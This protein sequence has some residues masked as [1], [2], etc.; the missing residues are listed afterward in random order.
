VSAA[1]FAVLG[2]LFI[3]LWPA[4]AEEPARQK[5]TKALERRFDDVAVEG[6]YLQ[7]NSLHID[8]LRL[9]KNE[10]SFD[11]VVDISFRVGW[12]FH[13]YVDEVSIDGKLEGKPATVKLKSSG[14]SGGGGG[15]L[16]FNEAKMNADLKLDLEHKDHAIH[17]D[18]M[19]LD[20]PLFG[21]Y[22]IHV[23]E[24]EILGSNTA[25]A[26]WASAK[27][28]PA[29][30][31]PL[32]ID[33]GGG[34]FLRSETHLP[35]FDG[36]LTLRDEEIN[37][38]S[39]GLQSGD[40]WSV[41]AIVDVQR[42][43]IYAHLTASSV[44]LD[45]VVSFK[46]LKL[47]GGV[48]DID[49]ILTTDVEG[50]IKY[51]LKGSAGAK[52][53]SVQHDKLSGKPVV[54]NFDS[55]ID[56]LYRV[57]DK[58][59]SLDDTFVAVW[60][61]LDV[62]WAELTASI[63]YKPGSS[64]SFSFNVPSQSCRDVARAI[65][66]GIFPSDFSKFD[67]RGSVSGRGS[68]NIVFGDG[69]STTLEGG[70]DLSKCEIAGVPDQIE[71]LKEGFRHKVRARNGKVYTVGVGP[72][73]LCDI[74]Y[75]DIHPAIP[76]A[77]LVTEDGSF[78]SH[79]GIRPH[80]LTASLKRNAEAGEFRRGGSTLTMQMVKNALLSHEKTLARKTQELFLTWVIEQRLSKKRILE[81]YLSVVEYGP[82]IY[83]VCNASLH[84][85]G[86][87]VWQL[88]AKE[89]AFMGTLMPRPVQRH[90]YWCRN[91]IP[92]SYLAYVDTVM[93]RMLKKGIITQEQ[94]DEAIDEPLVF[95]R[96]D[97]H[98]TKACLKAGRDMLE[99]EYT[100]MSMTGFYS[101]ESFD[102]R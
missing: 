8:R 92:D 32:S 4:L 43:S 37:R 20:Q 99:G 65:P 48:F 80:H 36:S 46:D 21:P 74:W 12:N 61:D 91:E 6:F 72:G 16:H 33:F 15:R 89:A 52:H 44:R 54:L 64:V 10:A 50:G 70:L 14:S 31:F 26:A 57:E 22:A 82:G 13:F 76:G 56:G 49:A 102:G 67:L 53:L 28:D 86:K 88:N 101:E 59:F 84:Y 78:F 81:I 39:V 9:S 17:G 96:Q 98:G 27:V 42:R 47:K 71:K 60:D 30:L 1:S 34:S 23:Q 68:G 85:F 3:G 2:G 7:R 66:K 25:S 87:Y 63:D 5:F 100:Q 97:F 58:S 55:R 35:N 94:Y 18:A 93:L 51:R 75:D 90:A 45:E 69:D 29:Q 73:A 38:F 41:D 95:D 77:L 62:G 83:G 24:P 79:D 40:S 11:G 19:I